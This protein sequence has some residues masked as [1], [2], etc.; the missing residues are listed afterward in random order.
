MFIYLLNLHIY[1]EI[2]HTVRSLLWKRK[3]IQ[4]GSWWQSRYR[5]RARDF[6]YCYKKKKKSR[7]KKR[8]ENAKKKLYPLS[9]DSLEVIELIAINILL[10]ITMLKLTIKQ[11]Y[12]ISIK[13]KIINS[14]NSLW[15]AKLIC[16]IVD[17][18]K[19]WNRGGEKKNSIK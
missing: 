16:L 13:W 10:R 4:Y 7:K 8:K 18:C 17:T 6:H 12:I 11:L 5:F 2:N 14:F 3:D 19:N 15:Y 1:I 9:N